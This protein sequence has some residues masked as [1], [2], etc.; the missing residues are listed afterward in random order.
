MHGRG[1]PCR[2]ARSRNCRLIAQLGRRPARDCEVRTGL[3]V[4]SRGSRLE[5]SAVVPEDVRCDRPGTDNPA[6]YRCTRRAIRSCRPF[7]WDVHRVGV[8]D[9]PPVASRRHGPGRSVRRRPVRALQR[10]DPEIAAD[11]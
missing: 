7:L 3:F 2:P 11:P 9:A 10:R 8:R 1:P 4:R 6:R 5:R